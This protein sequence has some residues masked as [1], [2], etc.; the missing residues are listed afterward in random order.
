VAF[1]A[2]RPTM[3]EL[4]VMYIAV[5]LATQTRC[6]QLDL[7]T[8]YCWSLSDSLRITVDDVSSAGKQVGFR[9]LRASTGLPGQS[10]EIAELMAAPATIWD[11]LAQ[12]LSYCLGLGIYLRDVVAPGVQ[13]DQGMAL[14][15][16]TPSLVS[17]KSQGLLNA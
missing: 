4:E 5:R 12:V 10:A 16:S 3:I 7:A 11:A 8:T 2:P 9:P 14:T 6:H 1:L 13:L 17:S 15:A